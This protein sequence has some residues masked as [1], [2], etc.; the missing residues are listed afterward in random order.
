MTTTT[1]TS[2]FVA[3]LG[4]PNVGKSSL[5]N[6]IL[7]QKVSIVSPKP[8][9][10]RN[11]IVGIFSKPE[12]QIVFLDTPG[13]H[14][15]KG[16]LNRRMVDA[17]LGTV[18]E[19]DVIAVLIDAARRPR[20]EDAAPLLTRLEHAGKPAVLVANKID[21]IEKNA[22][23]PL[24]AEWKDAAPWR[25]IVPVSARTGDG[26]PEL[27]ELLRGTLPEG[28]SW[29]PEDQLSDLPERFLCGELIR[30]QLFLQLQQEL[31]YHAAVEVEEWEEGQGKGGDVV[32][33]MARIWVARDS[34]KP[35]VIGRGGAT[36]KALGT[37]ARASIE[38][39]LSSR[40]HLELSVGVE[41]DWTRHPRLVRRL[42]NFGGSP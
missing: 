33:I 22:L 38:R 42:G 15:A 30:E 16:D 36:I 41:P 24:I 8:Q 20:A 6:A 31:P 23:L 40:V 12:T 26:V 25:A 7:G 39:F 2:G 3:L 19:V 35:I 9:T 1:H 4:A 28:P 10:T 17:A 27:V 5:L 13:L 32:R 14:S 21:L 37:A 34:Q 29:F 11:R 18:A